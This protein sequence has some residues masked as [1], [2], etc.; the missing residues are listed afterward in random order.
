[1]D[2]WDPAVKSRLQSEGHAVGGQGHAGPLKR[3]RCCLLQR[4]CKA[5]K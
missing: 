3:L 4:S 1:M 5:E 2:C